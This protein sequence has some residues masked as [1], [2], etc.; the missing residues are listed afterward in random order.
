M[1]ASD[2]II[3]IGENA[4]FAIVITEICAHSYQLSNGEHNEYMYLWGHEKCASLNDLINEM[5][6]YNQRVR[7]I[8][9]YL[10]L[11]NVPKRTMFQCNQQVPRIKGICGDMQCTQKND[12]IN[13]MLQYN[14]L[15]RS[16]TGTSFFGDM[17]RTRRID[18]INKMFSIINEYRA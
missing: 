15:V 3:I 2:I 5:F 7:S 10:G 4:V 17:Q 8:L 18:L 13:E 1:S 11:C 9:V 16:I 14:Q 6:K 12:L